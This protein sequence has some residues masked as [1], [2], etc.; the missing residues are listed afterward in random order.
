MQLCVDVCDVI[1]RMC[2]TDVA[3][4]MFLSCCKDT[5]A[6]ACRYTFE[7]EVDC[8]HLQCCPHKHTNISVCL[9]KELTCIV[10]TIVK[11]VQL[12]I[13][14]QGVVDLSLCT[15]LDHLEAHCKL[16]SRMLKSIP[17]NVSNL[18]L[19]N[20]Q[21]FDLPEIDCADSRQAEVF[22]YSQ[23]HGMNK[24]RVY[25]LPNGLKKLGALESS[26]FYKVISMPHQ[27]AY[28]GARWMDGESWNQIK[29]SQKK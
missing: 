6:L 17:S 20:Y 14:N 22:M 16:E 1:A 15:R 25:R 19:W 24:R 26:G 23:K 11:V 3:R 5:R 28:L 18:C 10:P 13:D 8:R 2:P 21:F 29:A 9:P 12:H 4:K 27:R 7:D